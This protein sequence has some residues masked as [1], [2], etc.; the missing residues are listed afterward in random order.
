MSASAIGVAVS[1]VS[2]N[3]IGALSG[4]AASMAGWEVIKRSPMFSAAAASLGDDFSNMMKLNESN[5]VSKLRDLIPLQ[6]FVHRHQDTLIQ[7]SESLPQLS[8]MEAYIRFVI[9]K[10][11]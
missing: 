7:I 10:K 5:F 4:T 11:E 1:S 2:T 8:W 9:H 6:Q 3:S